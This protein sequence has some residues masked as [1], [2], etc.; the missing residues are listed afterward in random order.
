MIDHN[1]LAQYWMPFGHIS[2]YQR[3]DIDK[4]LSDTFGRSG[5][6]PETSSK[7]EGEE[8]WQLGD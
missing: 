4:L 1:N 3:V 7:D 8:S 6:D 5:R 2:F